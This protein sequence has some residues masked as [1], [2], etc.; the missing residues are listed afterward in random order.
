MQ[1]NVSQLLQEPIGAIRD[2]KVSEVVD[3]TGEGR[4]SLVEGDCRL[5]RTQRSILA[6]CSL[7]TEVKLNCS[8]CLSQFSHHLDLKFE[9][10]YLPTVDVATGA[11]M[12]PP[13]EPSTF[14]IDEH[15]ILD[16]TEAARQY[17]LLTIPMKPLCDE[18]CAG[19]CPN[20]GKN[21]NQ[22]DCDC[23]KQYADPRWSRLTKLL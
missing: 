7:G 22:G 17:S 4:G 16:L 5:L 18:D 2:C 6:T 9:E 19:I 8:R 10:E 1:I 21:L 11:P 14:T 13:E 23:P 15:H 12:P 20:C 3:I